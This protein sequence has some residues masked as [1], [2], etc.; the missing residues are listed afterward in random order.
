MNYYNSGLETLWSIRFFSTQNAYAIIEYE[1]DESAEKALSHKEDHLINNRLLKVNK[2]QLKEFVS[3][4]PNRTDKKTE[5]LD[6]I[7]TEALV[8]NKILGKCHTVS[9][10][11][12]FQNLFFQIFNEALNYS[13]LSLVWWA[14]REPCEIS[15]IRRGKVSD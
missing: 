13:K 11:G 2:R 1:T 5:A 4:V 7:K 8:V 9:F 12:Y 10:A 14:D 3:R 15:R 6:K